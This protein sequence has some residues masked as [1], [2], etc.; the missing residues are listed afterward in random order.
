M[1]SLRD[2]WGIDSVFVIP[3]ASVRGGI[4]TLEAT[5]HSSASTKTP[6]IS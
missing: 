1:L 5:P 3:E 2:R 4:I 6:E